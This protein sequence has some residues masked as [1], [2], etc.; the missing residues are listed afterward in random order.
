MMFRGFPTAW[1]ILATLAVPTATSS[2]Q[3]PAAPT[4]FDGK[5]VG[6]ATLTR[7]GRGGGGC[8]TIKSVDMT[9]AG[10]QVVIHEIQFNGGKPTYRGSVNAA[11][12]VSASRQIEAPPSNVRQGIFTVSGTIHD[13]VFTGQRLHGRWGCDYRFEM[14]KG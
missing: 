8:G 3:E 9:I 4:A 10:G 11:G 2:A 6:T 1:V 12:E 7:E 13:N 14:A 5:Y